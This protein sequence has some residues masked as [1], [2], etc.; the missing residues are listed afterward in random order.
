MAV[1]NLSVGKVQ[2]PRLFV[3]GFL[4]QICDWTKL[5]FWIFSSDGIVTFCGVLNRGWLCSK[6]HVKDFKQVGMYLVHVHDV[7]THSD[8]LHAPHEGQW[9]HAPPRLTCPK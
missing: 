9:H 2:A 1:L 3:T 8:Q 6:I 4:A 5:F 7:F